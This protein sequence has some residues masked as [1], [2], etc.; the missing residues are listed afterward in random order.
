[1]GTIIVFVILALWLLVVIFYIWKRKK[2]KTL[3]TCGGDC[4]NCIG[5]CNNEKKETQ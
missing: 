5:G 3:F 4:R 1:M 2:N